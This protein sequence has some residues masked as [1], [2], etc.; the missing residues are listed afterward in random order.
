MRCGADKRSFSVSAIALLLGA[1]WPLVS[2]RGAGIEHPDVGTVA[3]G[4]AG[5]YAAAPDGGLALQYNPAGLARQP[6]LRL[7]LDAS[8]A[9]QQ[10]RFTPASGGLAVSNQ[11]P[12]FLAP[13]GV[14]SYGLGAVGPVR[15]LTLALGATGPTAIGKLSYPDKGAQRYALVSSDTTIAYLSFGVAATLARWLDAGATLQLVKGRARFRQ[16]VWSGDAPGTDPG[17]DTVAKVDVTSSFIPTAVV[18]VSVHPSAR[19]SV[20]L[21]YRPR[22]SFRANGSLTTDLPMTALATDTRQERS[23]TDFVLPMPDVVRAGVLV[24]PRA[25]WLVEADVVLERWST[26][27]ALELLPN[28]IDIVSVNLNTRQTLPPIVFE[29]RFEDSWSVRVGGEHEALPGRLVLR[30]GYLHETSAVPLASTSVDFPNWERDAVSVGASIA[31]PRTPVTVDVAYAH[32]FLPT[33]TVSDS[34][35][36]QVVT[37]CL[38]TPGCV[39]PAPTVVGDGRYEAALDVA[40]LSLRLALGAQ[41]PERAWDVPAP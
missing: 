33:R 13:A 19:V 20:G 4:R 8:L 39:A 16:N 23:S 38:T 12:P 28:G 35:I 34:R 18:G 21:S 40:S 36:V 27:G 41:A 31:I 3:A 5:A 11:A 15:A 32:H 22:F 17:Q 24:R 29:K 2:A 9:W 6:G 7:T 10:L 30:A 14:V 26:L 37:P 25:R 1:A